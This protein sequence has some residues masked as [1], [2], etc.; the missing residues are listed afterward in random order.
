MNRQCL[1]HTL[2]LAFLPPLFSFAI[3]YS[4]HFLNPSPFRLL[5]LL[6]FLL[7]LPIFVFVPPLP[8]PPFSLSPSPLTPS[9]IRLLYFFPSHFP[10]VSLFTASWL[11]LFSS[12]SA[13]T[14]WPALP[15]SLSLRI[16]KLRLIFPFSLTPHPSIFL[17]SFPLYNTTR[18]FLALSFLSPSSPPGFH[19][20]LTLPG[21]NS[22][23][24]WLSFNTFSVLFVNEPSEE[25][26]CASY[27]E[28]KLRLFHFSLIVCEA[29]ILALV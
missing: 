9:L 4:S 10:Q 15:V 6:S 2:F 3:S 5:W 17:L 16:L 25:V 27:M 22:L 28:R 7:P 11:L 29:R 21:S 14:S 12:I 20:S 24:G 1:R 13:L 26:S 23:Q 18:P 8:L 19:F